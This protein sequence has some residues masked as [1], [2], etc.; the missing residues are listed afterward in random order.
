MA[1]PCHEK[2]K[3]KNSAIY[4]TKTMPRFWAHFLEIG[5]FV[6]ESNH[7]ISDN[8]FFCSLFSLGG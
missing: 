3:V 5:S 2:P 8:T 1:P 7:N 4:S 6:A